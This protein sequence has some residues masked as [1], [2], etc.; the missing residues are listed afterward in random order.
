MITQSQLDDFF[1]YL[2]LPSISADP[3][4]K[5]AMAGCAEWLRQKFAGL[6]FSA[7]IHQ[8]EGPPIVLARSPFSANKKTILIYGHYDVQ[9]VDPVSL[10]HNDP[11]QPVIENDYVVARGATD[12][13]GQTICHI[14]GAEAALK[15]QG[16]LP[17]NLIFLIEG[18]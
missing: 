8:T 3:Q 15:A 11:F 13:K 2:R 17:V 9:P 6:G 1:A 7:A 12:N 18:E 5:P 16:D 10:W 14:L 4:Q